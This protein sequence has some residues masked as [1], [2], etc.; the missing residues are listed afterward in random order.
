MITAQGYYFELTDDTVSE[1]IRLY[2]IKHGV[3]PQIIEYST[4]QIGKINLPND[5]KII[6][7]AIRLPLNHYLAGVDD[8]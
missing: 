8:K 3:P 4:K 6:V 7:R 2:Q 1:I 5:M